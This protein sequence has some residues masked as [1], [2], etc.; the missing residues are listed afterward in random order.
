MSFK[1][2]NAN[3]KT[4]VVDYYVS[5]AGE[6]ILHDKELIATLSSLKS[7]PD[8]IVSDGKEF[9]I[10]DLEILEN[11][12][13]KKFPTIEERMAPGTSQ[14]YIIKND[15]H[16][17]KLLEVVNPFGNNFDIIITREK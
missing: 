16:N 9:D 6:W 10:Q 7:I 1:I 14:S 13:R 3:G 15:S 5:G 8:R 2:D 12:M 17:Q 11:I 4:A